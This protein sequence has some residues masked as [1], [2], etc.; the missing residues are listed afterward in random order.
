MLA[1]PLQVTRFS[2]SLVGG[3]LGP[4]GGLSLW[5]GKLVPGGSVSFGK[6]FKAQHNSPLTRTKQLN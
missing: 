6:D 2:R 5:G 4:R 3:E 1:A